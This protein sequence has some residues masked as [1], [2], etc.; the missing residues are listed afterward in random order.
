MKPGFF[1]GAGDPIIPQKNP[2]ADDIDDIEIHRISDCASH[3]Q[4]R[5]TN[6]NS[7]N[8]ND[9]VTIIGRLWDL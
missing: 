4:T 6:D 1:C 7:T 9:A 2:V 3:V 5:N 8:K